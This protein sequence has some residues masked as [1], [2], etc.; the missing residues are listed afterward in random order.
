[1]RMISTCVS[2]MIDHSTQTDGPRITVRTLRAQH[3]GAEVQLQVLI[4]DG[5]HC[6][7]KSIL[8]TTEQYTELKP[9][10]GE[11]SREAYEA[12]EAAGELCRAIRSGESLLSFGANSVGMLVV[13]LSKKGYS[14]DIAAKAAKQLLER[15]LINEEADVTREVERSL[16]KLWGK[17]RIRAH[18]WSRGFGDAALCS[19]DRFLEKVDFVAAC[20]QLI[21]KHYGEV[22]C[23]ADEYRRMLSFLSRYG[24]SVGEIRAAVSVLKKGRDA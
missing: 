8:L 3:D 2:P 16:S 17:K 23:D 7:Q 18:L 22:P 1:M 15:G 10:R 19:A 5:A 9:R 21:Q 14:R 24:Y 6:E 11:I 13:K 12:L 4:E 20:R